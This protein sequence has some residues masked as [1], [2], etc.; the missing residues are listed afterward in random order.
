[1]ALSIL[2][3]INDGHFNAVSGERGVQFIDNQTKRI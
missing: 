2:D 1:M 3:P